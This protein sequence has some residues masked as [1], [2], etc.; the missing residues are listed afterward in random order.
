MVKLALFGGLL[1]V[2]SFSGIGFGT[3]VSGVFGVAL[4]CLIL[5]VVL[6]V[7]AIV[8]EGI[9]RRC[10]GVPLQGD[11]VRMSNSGSVV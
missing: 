7:A 10:T 3:L 1:A 5:A 8:F 4:G 2:L 9:A 11:S 6:Q